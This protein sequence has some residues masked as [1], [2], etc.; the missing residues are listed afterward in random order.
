M[1]KSFKG[2][3]EFPEWQAANAKLQ[4]LN[5]DR[6]AVQREIESV[7]AGLERQSAADRLT[8]DAMAL[9]RGED[10]RT[11]ADLHDRL[12][13]AYG[14]KRVILK[15]IE[16]QRQTIGAL[17][18]KLSGQIAVAV[19]PDYTAL[20][21]NVAQA[22]LGLE[23]AIKAEQEFRHA[24]N[25]ADVVYSGTLRPVIFGGVGLLDDYNSRISHFFRE[26]AEAG[27][28]MPIN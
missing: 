4:E 15:A 24:L 21:R 6:D 14:R 17:R 9:I 23:R 25:D 1:K 16:I 8:D 13:D 7:L 18:D 2:L 26:G 27:H 5:Q 28:L 22:A 10:V 12:A 11:R 20:V 19:K 3:D